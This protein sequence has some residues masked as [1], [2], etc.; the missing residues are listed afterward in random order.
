MGL[1]EIMKIGTRIKSLR[2]EKGWSQREMAAQLGLS[3]ST[4]S[5]YENNYRT[6]DTVTLQK[7]AS[8]LGVELWDLLGINENIAKKSEISYSKSGELL[9]STSLSKTAVKSMFVLDQLN[10]EGQ[11][12]AY[13]LIELVAKI[14]EYQ[15]NDLQITR[16]DED[17][18]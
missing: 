2:K 3:Y 14:P 11:K 18:S 12:I 15:K 1:N 7:I 5:N 6:P 17:E 8:I 16:H 10:D 4:Y 13:S 9:V